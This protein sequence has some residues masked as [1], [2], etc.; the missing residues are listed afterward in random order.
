MVSDNCKVR[1]SDVPTLDELGKKLNLKNANIDS[2]IAL[3][4]PCFIMTKNIHGEFQGR[5]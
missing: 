1:N 4:S 2:I 3:V 5:Y